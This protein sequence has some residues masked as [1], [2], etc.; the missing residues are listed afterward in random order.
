MRLVS[1]EIAI[2]LVVL[3]L[4]SAIYDILGMLSKLRSAMLF[5]NARPFKSRVD[6]EQH[7][8]DAV[9]T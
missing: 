7:L 4:A 3:T 1:L 8:E 2:Q 6:Y 5:S 9:Q